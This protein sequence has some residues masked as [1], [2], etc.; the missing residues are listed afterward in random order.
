MKIELLVAD[1]YATTSIKGALLSPSQN[2][3]TTS[4][5]GHLPTSSVKLDKHFT[6]ILPVY[7]KGI[8]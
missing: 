2:W 4:K 1:V 7:F 3:L 5:S 6:L 8:L